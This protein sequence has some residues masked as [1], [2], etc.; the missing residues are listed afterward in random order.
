MRS[1]T[2][3][4]IVEQKQRAPTSLCKSCLKSRTTGQRLTIHIWKLAS[5]G[6]P[7]YQNYH[8]RVQRV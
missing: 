1:N 5:A 3:L 6:F 7:E 8:W 4:E 2:T